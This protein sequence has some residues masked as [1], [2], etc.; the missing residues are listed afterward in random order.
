V[1]YPQLQIIRKASFR[2]TPWKNGGGIT[3]E[4]IR[5]PVRGEPSGE[6]PGKPPGKP[7][8]WRVS[9]AHIDASGPFSEF[10]EHHRTMVLLRG[11]GIELRF[12]SGKTRTLAEPGEW[13]EFDGAEATY[14]ELLQGPCVDLNL[15]V[16]KSE[17]VAARV[18]RFAASLAVSAAR[19]ETTLVF[20]ID[21]RCTLDIGAESEILEPWD[22]A[23]LSHCAGHLRRLEATRSS[24]SAAV[25]LATLKLVSGE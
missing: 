4:A 12:G 15:M 22:L 11:A 16:L 14:C 9:V 23:L 6:P 1:Q 10:A 13:V 17:S 21:S 7:F 20:A 25:F 3:H 24:A 19:D 8:H 18:E 5:V 2:A